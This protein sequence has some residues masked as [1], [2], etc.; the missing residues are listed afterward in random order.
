MI[1]NQFEF[2]LPLRAVSGGLCI[3]LESNLDRKIIYLLAKAVNFVM[4]TNFNNCIIY[5]GI[6]EMN[7][8]EFPLWLCGLR[9]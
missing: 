5:V 8:Q 9:I 6:K 2:I 7:H 3:L 4:E 1:R